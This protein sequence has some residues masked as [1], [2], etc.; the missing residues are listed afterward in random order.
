MSRMWGYRSCGEVNENSRSYILQ[1]GDL[2]IAGKGLPL[3]GN[4][5]LLTTIMEPRMWDNV[6]K[7]ANGGGTGTS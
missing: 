2:D 7:Y 5:T 1:R 3:W 4:G 6:P